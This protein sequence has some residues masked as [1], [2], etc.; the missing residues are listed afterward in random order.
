MS[1]RNTPTDTTMDVVRS[2]VSPTRRSGPA[3]R[4]PVGA[5][6]SIDGREGYSP[7]M[8]ATLSE[9]DGFDGSN[10]RS[11]YSESF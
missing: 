4:A 2:K 8:A 3:D 10:L 7:S 9:R 11:T 5:S 1:T 6:V